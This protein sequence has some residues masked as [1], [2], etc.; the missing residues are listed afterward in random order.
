MMSDKHLSSNAH[1]ITKKDESHIV[2]YTRIQIFTEHLLK[3]L[4]KVLPIFGGKGIDNGLNALGWM[5][6]SQ[7]KAN[8][9]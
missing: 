1:K 9:H 7:N 2:L 6:S 5:D 8:K 3:T 4:D